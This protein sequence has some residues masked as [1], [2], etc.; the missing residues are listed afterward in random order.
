MRTVAIVQA[1]TGSRRLPGKVLM[2]LAGRPMIAWVL[3]RAARAERVDEVVL[4]T[5]DLPGDD[6]LAALAAE[7]GVPCHRGSEGDVLARFRDAARAAGAG[8]VV[9]ITGDC[10]LVAPEVVDAV[11]AALLDDPARVDL[12]SNV[13]ERTYP[14]GLDTEAVYADALERIARMG[15]S[16]EAREHVTWFAYRERPDL[17]ALR[18]V[19]HDHD[20]SAADWSVDSAADLD[21][22][23][24]LYERFGLATGHTP[25]TEIA[26][27]G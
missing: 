20:L 14:K 18:S 25:W 13:L 27:A 24:E 17:F 1:R 9:R 26:A 2:D 23:R 7:L 19:R 5:S 11:A 12:A 16:P 21:R 8:A 15:T 22:V 4:A 10:P 3:E 6:E